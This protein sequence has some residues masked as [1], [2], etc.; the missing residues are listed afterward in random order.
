MVYYGRLVD[1]RGVA[2]KRATAGRRE[3]QE[4]FRNEVSFCKVTSAGVLDVTM[5][6]KMDANMDSDAAIRFP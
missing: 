3:T 5:L 2:V 6:S 4:Q 1:G